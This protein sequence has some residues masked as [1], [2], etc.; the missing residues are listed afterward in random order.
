MRLLIL[1]FLS[2]CLCS[3]SYFEKKKI[4]SK[5]ILEQ[6]LKTSTWNEVDQYPSFESCEDTISFEENKVCFETTLSTYVLEVLKQHQELVQPFVNDTLN[7]RF[8][9]TSSGKIT[10]SE[11]SARASQD[12]SILDL[13]TILGS[14]LN[15]LPVL[16]PAIKRG[17]HVEVEFILPIIL[18]AK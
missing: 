4:D 6:E 11:L 7:L 8:L 10:L 13:E 18:N 2:F 16:Y 12:R 3:C 5:S 9:V 1:L 17:Q 14:A 15:N